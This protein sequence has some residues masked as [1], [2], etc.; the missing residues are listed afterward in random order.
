MDIV[1]IVG[2]KR[3]HFGKKEA[4]KI[5]KASNVPCIIYNGKETVH[6]FT[7]MALFKELVY[8][9]N[10]YFVDLNLEGKSYRCVLKEIQFHPVSEMIM[11]V[12]F[13]EISDHKKVKMEIPVVFKGNAPGIAEGGMLAKKLRK[14]QVKAYP[15]DMPKSIEVDISSL[16]LGKTVKVKEVKT[17]NYEILN[18][19]LVPIAMIEKILSIDFECKSQVMS[20]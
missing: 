17:E 9:P 15:K 13:L 5:R 12:D 16:E 18:V 10:A 2:Y 20:R 3:T 8:T 11:H 1:E 14:L 6:F 7:P 19:P 4:K